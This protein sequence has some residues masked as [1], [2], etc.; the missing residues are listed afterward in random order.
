MGTIYQRLHLYEISSKGARQQ[1]NSGTSADRPSAQEPMKSKSS[2][3]CAPA[4]D[5]LDV[6]WIA[7]KGT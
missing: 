6:S 4:R 2:D 7:E 5:D 1:R 3:T